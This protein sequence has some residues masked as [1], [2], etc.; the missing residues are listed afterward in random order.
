MIDALERSKLRV[1][2]LHPSRP[3]VAQDLGAEAAVVA[4]T[5]LQD[6]DGWGRLFRGKA[7]EAS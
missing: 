7:T 6:L 1:K 3:L 2:R 5:M 4:T